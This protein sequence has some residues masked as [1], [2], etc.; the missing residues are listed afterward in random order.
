MCRFFSRRLWALL[1]LTLTLLPFLM[2]STSST[3]QPPVQWERTFGG[4]GDEVG[5]SVQQTADGGYIIA[6]LARRDS[7]AVPFWADVHLIK[8]DAWGNKL[9]D[10][11]FGGHMRLGLGLGLLRGA[12]ASVQETRDGGFIIV[13]TRSSLASGCGM[14]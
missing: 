9:W 8:T 7:E 12:G 4:Q 2:C 10:K 5:Y 13:G 14:S 11:T 3:A 1:C 6:A